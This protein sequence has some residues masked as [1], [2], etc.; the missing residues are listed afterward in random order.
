MHKDKTLKYN[1]MYKEQKR[2]LINTN[3]LKYY[4]LNKEK[5]KERR[6]GTILCDCGLEYVKVRKNRHEKTI[7][8]LKRMKLL[9]V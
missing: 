8:H 7:R 4:H 9:Q 2:E 6:K 3:S 1:N 5:I